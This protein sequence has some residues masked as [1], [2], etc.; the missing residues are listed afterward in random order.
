MDKTTALFKTRSPARPSR[1]TAH[2]GRIRKA[3]AY[4]SLQDL[5]QYVYCTTGPVDKWAYGR[6]VVWPIVVGICTESL[7]WCVKSSPHWRQFVAA[8][9]GTGNGDNLSPA[10]ATNCR[11]CGRAIMYHIASSVEPS[12][13]WVSVS[14]MQ[15]FVTVVYVEGGCRFEPP[16]MPPLRIAQVFRTNVISKNKAGKIV[17]VFLL[18]HFLQWTKYLKMCKCF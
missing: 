15:S 11:Q 6:H 14:N 12:V 17:S 8:G 7:N 1:W 18:Y 10:T 16:P 3:S 9:T 4:R 5:V 13:I 2:M